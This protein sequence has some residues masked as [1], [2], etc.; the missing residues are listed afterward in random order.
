MVG[1]WI[2]WLGGEGI[3]LCIGMIPIAHAC[4]ST[5]FACGITELLRKLVDKLDIW[6]ACLCRFTPTFRH[7]LNGVADHLL[8]VFD[9]GFLYG[10]ELLES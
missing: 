9:L 5:S 1:E 3:E 4:A 8:Q 6:L 10:P 7:L 2:G